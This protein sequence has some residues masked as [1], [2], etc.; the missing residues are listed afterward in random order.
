M[1]A[2]AHR[3]F[4]EDT[5][6]AAAWPFDSVRKTWQVAPGAGRTLTMAVGRS[7][8]HDWRDEVVQK[9]MYLLSFRPGWDSYE[10]VA[11]SQDA[12]TD[13]FA[14]L[15]STMSP[16]APSPAIVPSSHGHFQAEWHTPFA[17]LEVEVLSSAQVVASYANRRTGVQWDDRAFSVDLR[18]I[19][20][21]IAE[22]AA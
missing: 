3:L 14:V 10:S 18:E 22:V 8:S 2:A 13:M 19:A 21:A 17:D 16:H 12:A 15:T 1:N 4:A 11:P 5:P 9:L 20:R 7:I 6:S